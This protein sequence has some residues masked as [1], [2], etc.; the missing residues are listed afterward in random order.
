MHPSEGQSP[1][2]SR[3]RR[4]QERHAALASSCDPSRQ[5]SSKQ[6]TNA[7]TRSGEAISRCLRRP[8]A[9]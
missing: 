3:E 6:Y 7:S 8:P 1:D 5:S 2:P 4:H 9:R